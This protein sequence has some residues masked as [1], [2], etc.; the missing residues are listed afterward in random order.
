MLED[1]RG[2]R[3]RYAPCCSCFIANTAAN[4]AIALQRVKASMGLAC[5]RDFPFCRILDDVGLLDCDNANKIPHLG[6]SQSVH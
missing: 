5:K 6:T 2:F 3:F 4:L 1:D